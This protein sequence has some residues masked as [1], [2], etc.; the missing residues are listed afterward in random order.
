MP[1]ILI[2]QDMTQM[3]VD[4]IVNAANKTL[5]GGGGVDGAIHKAA[6]PQLLEACRLLGGCQVGDAK[7]TKG[8]DL[9]ASY[10]IHTVGPIWHG[11]HSGEADQLKSCYLKA[12]TIAHDLACETMAFPLISAGIYG[13]PKEQVLSLAIETISGFLDVHDMTVYL[14]VYKKKTLNLPIKMANDIKNFISSH[15]KKHARL[16]K[17]LFVEKMLEPIQVFEEDRDPSSMGSLKET[18]RHLEDLMTQLDETFSERLL[19]LIDEKGFTD[20][21]TY[22]KANIDR[23]LFSKIRSDKN[24]KPS[25]PTVLAFAI[26]LRLSIDETKDLLLKAGFGLSN[27]QK[28]DLIVQYFIL[29]KTYDIHLINEAL[30]MFDQPLLGSVS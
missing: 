21:I 8:Y 2:E 15:K 22:K 11:G 14:V 26:A 23:K 10:V 6:G 29:E 25:K 27:S 30:F 17:G 18:K 28:L 19:R 20:T 12:L 4:A 7:L 1:L 13:Y 24:Y 16:N 5:L 9:P 3:H